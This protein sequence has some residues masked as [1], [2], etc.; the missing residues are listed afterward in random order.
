[1]IRRRVVAHGRVQGVGF[2]YSVR[3]RARQRGVTG[4][5]A[6]RPDGSVEAVFEGDADAVEQLVR[7]M[8]DGPRGADVRRADV[9]DE[10]PEGVRGFDVR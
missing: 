3:Q 10:E 4:W 5:I 9:T 6:N 2:R 8:E 7:L 1:V